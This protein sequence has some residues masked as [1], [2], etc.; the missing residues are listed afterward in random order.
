MVSL[1]TLINYL[2]SSPELEKYVIEPARI[3]EPVLTE[4]EDLPVIYIGY[5]SIDSENP[6]TPLANDLYN[7]HGEDLF[8]TFQVQICAESCKFPI[9]WKEVYRAL[10]GWHPDVIELQHTGFTYR[11]GGV[12]GIENSRLWWVDRW[13]IGFPLTNVEI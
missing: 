9:V 4:L 3:K 6:T 13:T 7:Q 11:Q 12:M 1:E 5:E 8:Q 10:I 2:R